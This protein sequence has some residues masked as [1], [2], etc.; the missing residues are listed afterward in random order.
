MP[1]PETWAVMQWSMGEHFV[2]S[3]NLHGGDLV[4]NYPYD[5][6]ANH[7]N[8]QYAATPDDDVFRSLAT[9]YARLNPPMAAVSLNGKLDF[10]ISDFGIDD[11][12]VSFF[13]YRAAISLEVLRMELLG[14]CCMEECRTG[15]TCRQRATLKSHWSLVR[16]S[17]LLPTL[18]PSSGWIIRIR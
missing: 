3:S 1:Q 9:E 12:F 8:G 14:M 2:L 11:L 10:F 4:A 16:P 15:T 18:W 5:G 17:G 6:N 7:R 13:S